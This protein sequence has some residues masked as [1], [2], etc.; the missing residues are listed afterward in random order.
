M[1][2]HPTTFVPTALFALVTLVVI[3]RVHVHRR[4]HFYVILFP[5]LNPDHPDLLIEIY[6][7]GEPIVPFVLRA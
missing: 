4:C 6:R 7:L 1:S 5:V 3:K 2:E